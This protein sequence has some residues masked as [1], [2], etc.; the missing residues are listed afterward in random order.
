MVEGIIDQIVPSEFALGKNFP[1]PF[2]PSTTISLMIP[3]RSEITLKVFNILGQEITTLYQGN[4]DA[5]IHFFRWNGINV[6][7][8]QAPSGIYIY[9]MSTAHGH[10]LVRKMVLIR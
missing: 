8:H 5:G 9:A 4:L 7:G 3:E 1:N 2:N 6:E 10:Q